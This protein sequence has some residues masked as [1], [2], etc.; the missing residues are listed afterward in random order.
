MRSGCPPRVGPP[1]AW[2]SSDQS[3]GGVAWFEFPSPGPGNLLFWVEAVNPIGNQASSPV[4]LA[5]DAACPTAAPTQLQ[6]D[7]LDIAAGAGAERVYCYVSF[8]DAPEAR[9]PAQE[10]DFIAVQDGHGDL[11]PWSHTF[12]L[13][14][15]QDGALDLSGE[16]WGWA[17]EEPGQTGNFHDPPGDRNLGRRAA[18]G[19]GKRHRDHP[20]HRPSDPGGNEDD[21]RRAKS[22]LAAWVIPRVPGR[23]ASDRSYAAGPRDSPRWSQATNYPLLTAKCNPSCQSLDLEVGR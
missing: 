10:G 20:E 12:T 23:H 18:P 7:L 21:L 22:G 6:V 9:L 15:P 17:G 19:A 2:R 1:P 11:T 14:I 5:L 13:P 3:S 4:R 8:E 16:C